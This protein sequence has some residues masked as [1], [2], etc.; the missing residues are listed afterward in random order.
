MS[1]STFFARAGRV[2]GLTI[3]VI[4]LMVGGCKDSGRVAPAGDDRPDGC[5]ISDDNHLFWGIVGDTGTVLDKECFIINHNDEGKIPAWVAY[6]L[7]VENLAGSAERTDDFRPDPELAESLRAELADY[8]GSG[9]DRGH[10]AP[11]ACFKRSE[12]A[13]SATFLLSNMSPQT[14]LL[15]RG[16]WRQLEQYIRDITEGA[17]AAWI[18]TGNLFLDGDSQAVSPA[19]F[20]GPG[21]VAVPTHCF[22]AILTI[23]PDSVF[24]A[25]AF[26][27]P[28]VFDSIDG[29]R[30][31]YALPVD[32]LEELSGYDFFP[33]LPDSI[34]ATIET[35]N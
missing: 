10:N 25:E 23:T 19:V 20:I 28:N 14:P 13:M 3:F 33:L 22:K 4:Y 30:I 16:K 8:R 17:G 26:L 31:D 11:A 18:F 12:A 29:D 15:N 32:R 1:G 27:L 6:Y 9:Y 34:E 7:S 5:L 21:R 2:C 24:S 35:V